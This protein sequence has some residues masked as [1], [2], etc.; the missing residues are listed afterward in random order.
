MSE[1]NTTRE[2]NSVKASGSYKSALFIALAVLNT[3]AILFIGIFVYNEQRQD[4]VGS[5]TEAIK[6]TPGE[7]SNMEAQRVGELIPLKTFL[8]NLAGSRGRKLVKLSMELEIEGEGI[9]K[10]IDH[11]RPKIRDIIIILLSSKSY[12]EISNR[13]GKEKLRDEIRDQVNLFLTKGQIRSVY[14]TQLIFS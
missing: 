13:Q 2:T 14:F 9:Q 6:E 7:E 11:L 5:M 1:E 3:L 4:G 12:A 8:V 10:E